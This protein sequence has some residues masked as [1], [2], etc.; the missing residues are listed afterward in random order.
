MTHSTT[1]V[2]SYNHPEEGRITGRNTVNI[3]YIKIHNKIEVH[4]LVVYTFYK[5]R[6]ILVRSCNYN[7][8]TNT[9]NYG[10]KG[11]Y[12]HVN[13]QSS[14][15]NIGFKVKGLISP[16]LTNPEFSQQIFVTETKCE[17]SRNFAHRERSCPE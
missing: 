15:M 7:T 17:T 8:Y 2:F 11:K 9:E 1:T 5:F 3:L 6:N 14:R 13:N 4:L 12:G 16:I 10:N